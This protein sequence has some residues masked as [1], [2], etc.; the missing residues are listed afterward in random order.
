[1]AD[2]AEKEA[3]KKKTIFDRT[4]KLVLAGVLTTE[5]ILGG[6]G[7][8]NAA[9]FENVRFPPTPQQAYYK[10]N[11]NDGWKALIKGHELLLK[12]EESKGYIDKAVNYFEK[13]KKKNKDLEIWDKLALHYILDYCY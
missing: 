4:R 2:G 12:G 1:M 10:L 5:I 13:E 9:R 3:V 6:I 7:L 8:G 11:Y